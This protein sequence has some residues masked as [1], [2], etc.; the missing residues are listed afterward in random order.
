MLVPPAF[1][2]DFGGREL[3]VYFCSHSGSLDWLNCLTWFLDVVPLLILFGCR[4]DALGADE[5]VFYFSFFNWT[6]EFF[7]CWLTASWDSPPLL[8]YIHLGL[9]SGFIEAWLLCLSAV[10]QMAG[11]NLPS[12]ASGREGCLSVCLWVFLKSLALEDPRKVTFSL[13]KEYISK[14]MDIYVRP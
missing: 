11:D 4:R 6:V 2:A 1:I 7:S 14:R 3:P 9:W 5:F 12:P 8:S 10:G 13:K